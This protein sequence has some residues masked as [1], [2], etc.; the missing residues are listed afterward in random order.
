MPFS[1]QM[2]PSSQEEATKDEHKV[3]GTDVVMAPLAAPPIADLIVHFVIAFAYGGDEF[4]WL[5]TIA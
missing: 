4:R 5:G 2:Q 1:W 3:E